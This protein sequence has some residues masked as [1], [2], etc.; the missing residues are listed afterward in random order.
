MYSRTKFIPL[1]VLLAFVV[2]F[3][4]LFIFGMQPEMI[5]KEEAKPATTEFG[6]GFFGTWNMCAVAI[7]MKDGFAAC[8]EFINN[9]FHNSTSISLIGGSIIALVAIALFFILSTATVIVYFVTSI[10][11]IA[12][13]NWVFGTILIILAAATIAGITISCL[14]G[15]V[16]SKITNSSLSVEE[17]VDLLRKLITWNSIL[18]IIVAGCSIVISIIAM[19]FQKRKFAKES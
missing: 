12:R 13:K 6:V 5:I 2:G 18:T 7:S 10:A 16:Y 9:I 11:H 19:I 3:C 8:K 17:S 4:L 15:L 1:I 14:Y